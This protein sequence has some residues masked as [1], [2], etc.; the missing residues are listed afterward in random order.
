MFSMCKTANTDSAASR[1]LRPA[2]QAANKMLE[3]AIAKTGCINEKAITIS[4]LISPHT[5]IMPSPKINPSI[6]MIFG[7]KRGIRVFKAAFLI[8]T[9]LVNCVI[10]HPITCT[11]C[12]QFIGSPI[13]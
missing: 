1:R 10:I 5:K 7:E 4:Q 11:G 2:K 6:F 13:K 12:S 8:I 9:K 3:M